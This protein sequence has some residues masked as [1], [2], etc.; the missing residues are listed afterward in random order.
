MA[1]EV[2]CRSKVHIF[3][4]ILFSTSEKGIE[5]FQGA[6]THLSLSDYINYQPCKR[7]Y[8]KALLFRGEKSC[9]S[10]ARARVLVRLS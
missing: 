10:A 2:L 3:H 1:I 8:S 5:I 7:N 6:L 9:W 4:S